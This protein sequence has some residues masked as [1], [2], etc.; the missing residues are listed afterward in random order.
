MFVDM[1]D[2]K[3]YKFFKNYC[4]LENDYEITS[5]PI[6]NRLFKRDKGKRF[7]IILKFIHTLKSG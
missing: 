3:N 1:L 4:L 6:R 7:L 5:E 2:R